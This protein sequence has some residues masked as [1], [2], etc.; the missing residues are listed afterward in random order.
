MH[1]YLHT[2][3]IMAYI[4]HTEDAIQKYIHALYQHDNVKNN[5][6]ARKSK[7]LPQRQSSCIHT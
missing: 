3:P 1:I 6:F 7:Y 2:E 5:S 4:H